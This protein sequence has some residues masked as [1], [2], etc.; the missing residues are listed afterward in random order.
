VVVAVAAGSIT[1]ATARS[2][3]VDRLD[4][5]VR[6]VGLM[7]LTLAP[8]HAAAALFTVARSLCDQ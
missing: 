8:V 6:T 1:T 4:G 7:A 2:A 5:R 3:A